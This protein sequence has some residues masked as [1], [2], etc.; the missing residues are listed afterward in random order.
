MDNDHYDW[1]AR[2]LGIK[3]QF[4]YEPRCTKMVWENLKTSHATLLQGSASMSKSY[5]GGV[6]HFLD[7]IRDPIYTT[8]CCWPPRGCWGLY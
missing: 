8:S 5:G 2:M 6:W 7:W 3:T 4:T 1:A